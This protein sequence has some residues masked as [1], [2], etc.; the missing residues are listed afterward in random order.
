MSEMLE[1]NFSRSEQAGLGFLP[2]HAQN[3][4]SV[5]VSTGG[6]AEIRMAELR[7]DATIVATTLDEKGVEFSR[8]II[9]DAGLKDRVTVKL[10][11]VSEPLPYENESFDYVYAR[12]VLHY[13]TKQALPAALSELHRVLK[14][15]AGIFVVVRSTE[16][17][18]FKKDG[19]TYDEETGL[20]RYIG[21]DG[22]VCFRQFHTQDSITKAMTAAGFTIDSVE[23]YDEQLFIDYER[24]QI[25]PHTDNVIAL[26]GHK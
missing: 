5:G 21:G 11:D 24:K 4:Y 10:E 15:S 12:L 9:A 2:E 20:T 3:I 7:P 14:P 6:I 17:P 18:D 16:C 23:Q 19:A 13:L 8:S 26:A 22:K 1:T 25:A